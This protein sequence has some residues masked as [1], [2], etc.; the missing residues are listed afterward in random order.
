[1]RVLTVSELTAELAKLLGDR[2]PAIEVEGEVSQL[3]I[4]ASGHAYLTLTDGES[5]LGAVAWRAAWQGMVWTPKR[6]DRVVCR[7]KIGV[8]P[9]KGAYQ[10]YVHTI[11]KAGEGALAAEIARRKARL[12]AEGLLDPRRKRALPA[13]PRFVGVATSLTGAALQDFLKVSRDRFPAARILVSACTVQGTAAP[14]SVVGALELLLEDGRSD[15]LVVTRGG[16]SKEDLLA[17]QDEGLARFLAHC[18]VPVISAV[19]HQVD[20]TLADLV[21]DAVAPT[22]TAA[23]VLA[24]PDRDRLAQG[25][26]ERLANLEGRVRR[27]IERRRLGV[28]A[29]RR[30]LRH[31]GERLR[32]VRRRADDLERRLRALIAR[33]QESGAARLA[34]VEARLLAAASTQ[35]ERRVARLARAEARLQALSPR[36][37]LSRGYAVVR[38]P[39]GV[40]LRA[41]EV[42]PGEA[43]TVTLAHG[44]LAA[45]VTATEGA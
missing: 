27:L 15:V 45:T 35:R 36:A 1:M 37:V 32:D 21:A 9:G 34:A 2:Y 6:G 16:G 8:Y 39:R 3:A 33:R 23:A 5:V 10:L 40:L 7:G 31:P 41:D 30:R 26:D 38:G 19:G 29:L 20:T 14:A 24:L 18:P 17:F 22:P 11:R 12:E 28:E 13:M 43:L 44:E 42:A 4:P 25:V